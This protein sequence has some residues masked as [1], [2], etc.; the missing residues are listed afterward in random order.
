MAVIEAAP[1]V[2]PV[3]AEPIQ[4]G[5]VLVDGD[6]IAAVGERRELCAAH[7][8]V[9]VRKWRGVL[10]PGLVNAHTHLQYT[11]FAGLASL[12]TSFY[13]WLAQVGERRTGF[14]DPMWIAS[15]QRGIEALLRSGTT[16]AADIVTEPVVLEP[17]AR[18]G[19]A[20]ISYLEVVVADD[21]RWAR[22][23]RDQL[24]RGLDS[25]PEGR[26]VGVSPH[27]LYTVGTEVFRALAKLSRARGLRMHPHLAESA[28]EVRYVRDGAGPLADIARTSGCSFELS[29]V[30]T[31]RT[32]TA[33]MAF[34][35]ALGAD[36]HVAH[37]VHCD[38]ADRA[39]LREYGASVALCARSNA[40]LGVG[41]PPVAAYLAE[42]SPIAIG[43]DSLASSPSLDL[44]E[45]ARALRDLARR[46]GYVGSDL[47]RRI[48]DAATRGGA[49][50][51]GANDFGV[52]TPG[53]RADLAVFDVPVD[54]DPHRALIDHGAGRCTATIL[55]GHLVHHATASP[56]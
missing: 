1:V 54:S 40:T 34:L 24:L 50:A 46:Q 19:L 9:V 23:K 16:A 21:E 47:D 38:A 27:T 51:M 36:T 26:A 7:P 5:A 33:Q 37:G 41:D 32:P 10:T 25:V 22:T 14:T 3:A 31:Q 18:S 39:L 55:A 17:T 2:V 28:D 6:R 53:S 12:R 35:E 29:G 44:L 20:G 30:G 13:R 49:V 15:A 45:E 56:R 8:G 11:D 42:G 4:D 48:I 52:L 43:T